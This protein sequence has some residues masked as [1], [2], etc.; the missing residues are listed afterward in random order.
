MAKIAN[1]QHPPSKVTRVSHGRMHII[2]GMAIYSMF[3]DVGMPAEIRYLG[4]KST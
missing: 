3:H 2:T 4:A 1:L